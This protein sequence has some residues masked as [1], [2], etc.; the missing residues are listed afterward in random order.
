ML[1]P[2]R[3]SRS[4]TESVVPLRGFPRLL[5][6][7]VWSVTK[8]MLSL[9]SRSIFANLLQGITMCPEGAGVMGSSLV[10]GDHSIL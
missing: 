9:L 4:P 6:A 7:V 10:P 8:V 3:P 1:G 2:A 5:A